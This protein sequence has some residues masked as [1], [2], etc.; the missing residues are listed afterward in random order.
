MSPRKEGLPG[1]TVQIHIRTTTYNTCTKSHQ[2]KPHCGEEKGLNGEA[3]YTNTS[4]TWQSQLSLM[5]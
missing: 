5:E 2:T 1:T 3:V 4:Q